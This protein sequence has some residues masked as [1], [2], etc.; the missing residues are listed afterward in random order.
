MMNI[1]TTS[2]FVCSCVKKFSHS[3][4]KCF[5]TNHYCVGCDR[6]YHYSLSAARISNAMAL[7]LIRIIALLFTWQAIA[8]EG[9]ALSCRL[10]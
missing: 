10:Y 2:L 8:F 6:E 1:L 3:A 7:A 9:I 4:K 5:Y